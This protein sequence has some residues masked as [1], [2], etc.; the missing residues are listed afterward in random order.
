VFPSVLNKMKPYYLILSLLFVGMYSCVPKITHSFA[1]ENVSLVPDYSVEKNW[2]VLPFREDAADVVP[3]DEEWISDSLKTVDVFFV[4][5]TIYTK[6]SN[7]LVSVDDKKWNKKIDKTAI[8]FQASTFNKTGRVYSPRYRQAILHSFVDD[9]GNGR[10]ALDYCYSDVKAAFEYYMEHYNQGRPI[11]LAAHSQGTF[12]ARQLMKEFFDNPKDKEQLVCAYLVGF[13]VDEGDY[14][15]IKFCD[16]P[17]ETNC[18]VGWATYKEGH[19]PNFKPRIIDFVMANK[20]VNPISWQTDTLEAESKSA[21]L[22]GIEKKKRFK[23]K[24]RVKDGLVWVKTKTPIARRWT[25]LHVMDYNLF[26]NDIRENVALRV[27]KYWERRR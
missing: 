2:A 18:Y 4:Y 14:E 13:R 1:N 11:V 12:H 7:W 22:L 19:K 6:G 8:R 23:T 5:P 9:T 10:E 25:N 21:V 3:K 17:D 16:E 26:W 27:E 15:F 24:A 20:S